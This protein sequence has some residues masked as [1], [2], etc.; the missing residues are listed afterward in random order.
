MPGQNVSLIRR[1]FDEVWNHGRI[2]TIYELM[3]PNAIGIGQGGGKVA[4]HGPQQF[5]AFVETL[6]GAFPDITVTIEDAFES[7][8]KVVARWSATMTHKGGQLG[9]AAS[10]KSV[11]ISG[12]SIAQIVNGKIIAGWDRWDELGMM[13]AIGAVQRAE[14]PLTAATT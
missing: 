6:R 1:W 3:A 9:I 10:G 7:G 12:I 13:R 11:T 2:E 8:D 5:Q 4:L 14:I